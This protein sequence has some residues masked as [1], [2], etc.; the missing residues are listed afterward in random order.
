MY[1]FFYVFFKKDE[2]GESS[3][4]QASSSSQSQS[5]LPSDKFSGVSIKVGH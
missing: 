1:K 4:S 3:Q 5:K 2:E